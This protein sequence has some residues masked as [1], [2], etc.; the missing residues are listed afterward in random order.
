[1]HITY[2]G[3]GYVG[4]VHSVILASLGN[5]IIGYDTDK[6]KI[7]LLKQGVATNEEPNLQTLLT[8][9]RQYIRFTSN[10]RD[11]M[12]DSHI[13]FIAV[14]TPII[15]KGERDLS[16]LYDAVNKICEHANREFH[17]IIR[18]S[19]PIGT[20]RRLQKYISERTSQKFHVISYP[21]FSSEGR[22]VV[23][24]LNPD[25]V[26]LGVDNSESLKHPMEQYGKFFAKKV[27]ILIVKPESAELIDV[28]SSALCATKMSLFSE[29]AMFAEK[30][31]AD[32][33]E[34]VKGLRLDSVIGS[35]F[36][37][38][39]IGYSGPHLSECVESLVYQSDSVG[40][41]CNTVKGALFTNDYMI[42]YL[43][44]KILD[45][46]RSVQ[47]KKIA[48]LG[49]TY[50]GGTE[51]VRRSLGI[52]LVKHLLSKGA[53]IQLYD[54]LGE[55]KARKIF[56]RHTHLKYCDY[57]KDALKGADFAVITTNDKDFKCLTEEDFKSNM[58]KPIV[59]DCRNLFKLEDMK[60]IEYYSIGRSPNIKRH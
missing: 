35:K 5:D 31:D 19:V 7:A 22:M 9:A 46:F 29:L 6:E 24:M 11:A 10:A 60:S 47:S 21:E 34:V 53:D 40:E 59:F 8:E 50:K 15:N 13:F 38:P 39:N 2:I 51:D 52:N 56:S 27:P 23:E 43:F 4:L 30:V 55:E 28:S 58:R 17:L 36:T 1:M 33:D 48:I 32:I 20:N 45:R 54:P 3:L 18:S 37:H 12:A 44:R 49:I 26:V 16:K 25:R 57:I 41:P 42:D 14:D